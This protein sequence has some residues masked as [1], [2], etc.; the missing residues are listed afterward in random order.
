MVDGLI[1]IIPVLGDILD[2]LFK[3]NLRNLALLEVKSC[4]RSLGDSSERNREFK[5]DRI[6]YSKEDIIT[7]F[8]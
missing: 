6:G 5:H 2:A 3:S 4:S 1:G 8:K 7:T